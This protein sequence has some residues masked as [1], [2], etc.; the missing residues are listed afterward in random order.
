MTQSPVEPLVC[1]LAAPS[2]VSMLITALYNMVDTFFVGML[3]ASATGAVGVIFSLMAIIQ[4]AGFGFGHGSGNYISRKLGEQNT[5]EAQIMA[6]LGFGS[7]FLFGL[8]ILL[9]GMSS[10]HRLAM[11]LGSTP[12]ICPYAEQYMF[13][14]LLA[15][16]FFASSLT[17]NNQL[18][19]QGNA[20]FAMVGI[21]VG[22]VLNCLMDPVF[23]FL[24]DMGVRGAGLST[25]LSQLVS[26]VIL[27][28]GNERS[29]AVKLRPRFFRPSRSRYFEMLAGG[30]PSTARQGLQ[31]VASIVLN[32]CMKPFGDVAFAAMTIVI[33][34]T[35]LVFAGTA[36]IGQGFQPVCGFNWGARQYGRVRAA[37]VFT[38]RLALAFLLPVTLLLALFA[39]TIMEWFSHVGAVVSLSAVA[40]R[41]QCLSIPFMGVCI[42]SSMLFQNVGL[43][44]RATF[45]A[46]CR[47]G[48]FLIPLVLVL[49]RYL[50]FTGIML[51]QP[52]AD[53]L[54]FACSYPLQHRFL[55]RLKR[56]D[57]RSAPPAER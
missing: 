46:L 54:T 25:F 11:W 42:L 33:R 8:L 52:L 50:G 23:I 40:Q 56:L 2:V 36:G 12:T 35:N 51:A 6:A 30:F 18:R 15:A 34:L 17:L 21:G 49:P 4:A 32:H 19:L 53:L 24:L 26:F 44:G 38:E 29:D 7:S 14:I 20:R 5:R 39:P 13:F 9:L 57:A 28:W 37:Y 31:C 55:L 43:Y 16:P 1:S 3:G 41:W 45:I 47:S 22:A 10:M 27:L 48:L